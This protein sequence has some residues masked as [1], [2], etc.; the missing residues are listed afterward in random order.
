MN[1]LQILENEWGWREYQSY[2]KCIIDIV[3]D[4]QEENYYKD[5]QGRRKN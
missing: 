4:I 2:I 1:D 5:T 3:Y